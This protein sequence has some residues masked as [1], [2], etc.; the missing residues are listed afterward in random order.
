[1]LDIACGTGLNFEFI[2]RGIGSEG[3]IVGIDYSTGMLGKAR[4]KIRNH[5]WENIHLIREDARNLSAGL[6]KQHAGI[7]KVDRVL[8]T[9][10]FSV[11]PDWRDVFE[12]SYE[13][14]KEDGRYAIMDWSLEK[15]TPFARFLRFIAKGE[16]RGPWESRRTW[17]ALQTTEDFSHT[18][19]FGGR[20]FV[21]SGTKP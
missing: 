15:P 2:E 11:V 7:E 9:L 1:V 3:L 5:R 19:F 13:L 14:L 21:A 20:I 16:I 10:G 12:N 18:T 6:L 17:E 8:C 4:N